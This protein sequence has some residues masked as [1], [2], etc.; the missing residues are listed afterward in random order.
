M[1]E[2]GRMPGPFGIKKRKTGGQLASAPGPAQIGAMTQVKITFRD[3][4]TADSNTSP[5]LLVAV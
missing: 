2:S 1:A 3:G 4:L 5:V